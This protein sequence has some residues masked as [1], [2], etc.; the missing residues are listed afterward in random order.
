MLLLCCSYC[1]LGRFTIVTI[2]IKIE[3]PSL[4]REENNNNNNNNK[5]EIIRL[6]T[7]SDRFK[8]TRDRN[9]EYINN[10][11]DDLVI[12]GREKRKSK[13]YKYVVGSNITNRL[14]YTL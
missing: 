9:N 3:T 2:G 12:R 13:I 8:I 10:K 6:D 14:E 4:V 5:I 11:L 1:L 7:F